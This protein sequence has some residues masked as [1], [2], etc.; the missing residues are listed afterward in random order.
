MA[1]NRKPKILFCAST[2]GHILHF[3]L[4][5]LQAFRS[6]G[7]EVWVV[8]SSSQEIP[9]ADFVITLPF[10][11]NLTSPRNL[12]AIWKARKLFKEHSFDVV[13]LAFCFVKNFFILFFKFFFHL[14]Q[15][16]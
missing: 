14:H 4:P 10:E 8:A 12:Q 16:L 2:L 6:L 1:L 11:K 13:T 5:Y 7:Y 9:F 15:Q 3:H